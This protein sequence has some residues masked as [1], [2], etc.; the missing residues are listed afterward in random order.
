MGASWDNDDKNVSASYLKN[1]DTTNGNTKYNW[2]CV[3]GNEAYRKVRLTLLYF[4]D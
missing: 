4:S 2:E 3:G 1:F